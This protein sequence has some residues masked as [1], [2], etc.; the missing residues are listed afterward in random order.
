MVSRGALCRTVGVHP[1]KLRPGTRAWIALGVGVLAY[2]YLAEDEE[3][4][5][6]AAERAMGTY[7]LITRLAIGAISQHLLG[8]GGWWDPLALVGLVRKRRR[9]VALVVGSAP[10]CDG[11]VASLAW[12][13]KSI[14]L[15]APNE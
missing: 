12:P 3:T 4:L 13:S 1:M 5:S 11:P 10:T 6:D 15:C 9:P 14:R 2:D 8:T 7:P